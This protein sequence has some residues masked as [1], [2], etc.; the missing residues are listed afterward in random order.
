MMPKG[1]ICPRETRDLLL[2][3]CVEFI[4]M[5]AS[6]SNEACERGGRKTIAP[7]HVLEALKTLGFGEYVSEVEGAHQEHQMQSKE[8]EKTRSVSKFEESG[9]TEE[10]LL[11]QQE[12][13][14]AQARQKLQAAARTTSPF[15]KSEQSEIKEEKE[16]E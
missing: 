2:E 6:E 7:E 9:M 11:K 12:E 16:T 14:F 5:I 3:C 1:I 8:K 15:V 4:H 10:E 13:L